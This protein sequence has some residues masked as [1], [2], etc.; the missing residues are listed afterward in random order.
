[1]RTRVRVRAR[2]PSRTSFLDPAAAPRA[3]EVEPKPGKGHARG[4]ADADADDVHGGLSLP[5]RRRARPHRRANRART[6]SA[7]L[8]VY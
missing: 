2:P 7:R 6:R 1:M 3:L 4:C 8:Q 5:A